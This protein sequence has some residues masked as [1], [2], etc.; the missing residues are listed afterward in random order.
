MSRGRISLLWIGL[1]AATLSP[2]FCQAQQPP[3]ETQ[4]P[5]EEDKA[6]IQ[7]QF[8]FNPLQSNKDVAVGE[9]YFRKGSF[10]AAASR[11]LEA[12]KWNGGNAEAWLRLGDAE[13]KLKDMKAA[14]E[15]WEKY[16]QLA[17]EAKNAAEV[18]KKLGKAKA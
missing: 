8:S 11:F 17:P 3:E 16:L 14:R 15:A 18:R 2:L 5:P 1:A 7:E 9:A 6:K 10:N 4:L 13:A 12:T